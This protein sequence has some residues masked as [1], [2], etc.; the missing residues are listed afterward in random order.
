MFINSSAGSVVCLRTR[1]RTAAAFT[2]HACCFAGTPVCPHTLGRP[3]A[4]F[5]LYIC[6]SLGPLLHLPPPSHTH[7][8]TSSGGPTALYPFHI[9]T[10]CRPTAVF[11]TACPQL[12]RPAHMTNPPSPTYT[13]QVGLQ[14]Y[15][16]SVY[17]HSTGPLVCSH[18]WWARREQDPLELARGVAYQKGNNLC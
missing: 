15:F 8:P 5:L 7:T 6:S 9:C 18:S 10:F 17:T 12:P 1:G 3:I 2:L 16:H 13:I 14:P 4:V 11:P